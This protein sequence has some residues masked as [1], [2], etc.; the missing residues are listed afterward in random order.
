[1][2]DT[3]TKIKQIL[4]EADRTSGRRT[5]REWLL[6]VLSSL[7]VLAAFAGGGCYQHNLSGGGQLHNTPN[8]VAV[9]GASLRE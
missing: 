1:M 3:Q 2:Q 4:M 7:V 8:H 9:D 5:I 6:R